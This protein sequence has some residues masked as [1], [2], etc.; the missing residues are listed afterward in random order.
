LNVS[1]WIAYLCHLWNYC[2]YCNQYTDS[3]LTSLTA[4]FEDQKNTRKGHQMSM[5]ALQSLSSNRLLWKCV[6]NEDFVPFGM[7]LFAHN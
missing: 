2:R 6:R 5:K 1:E 7:E 3:I 4:H